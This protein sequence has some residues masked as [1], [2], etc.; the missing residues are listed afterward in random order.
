MS[1]EQRIKVEEEAIG[2]LIL[3]DASVCLFGYHLC[4][5]SQCFMSTCPISQWKKLN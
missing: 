1:I 2:E 5:I 4:F 3:N